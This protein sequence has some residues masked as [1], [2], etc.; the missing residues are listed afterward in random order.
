M[1]EFQSI[2]LVTQNPHE[3]LQRHFNIDVTKP[4]LDISILQSDKSIGIDDIKE[5]KRFAVSPPVMSAKKQ[6][7]IPESRRLTPEAQNALLKLLEEPPRYLQ[8]ILVTGNTH[9]LLE[10][11]LSR[12]HVITD[13]A[14]AIKPERTNDIA[15]LVSLDPPA[16]LD[17]L[18][19]TTTKEA[20]L[21]FC[22]QLI[23]SAAVH[24]SKNPSESAAHNLEALL[25]CHAG[26]SQNA[27]PTLAV[28]DAILS[29]LPPANN[30]A[31]MTRL[32]G[33]N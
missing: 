18:P 21:T 25:D 23:D 11:I 13:T 3:A 19:P 17:N 26:L 20:A 14:S 24:L 15:S 30:P 33:K 27:N 10:T 8:I 28:T 16:R 7:V 9:Q 6:I 4:G 22:R 2:L 12:C 32:P 29:L 31:T 1:P 5:A